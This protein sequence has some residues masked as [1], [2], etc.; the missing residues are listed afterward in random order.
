M[1]W[2]LFRS[3]E[4]V[5]KALKQLGTGYDISPD[6][7]CHMPANNDDVP[8]RSAVGD[9]TRSRLWLEGW[10]EQDEARLK[11]GHFWESCTG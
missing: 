1:L 2:K 3:D 9:Q 5:M 4:K 11:G 8:V 7:P 6:A 10:S